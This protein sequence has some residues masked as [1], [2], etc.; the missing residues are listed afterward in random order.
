MVNNLLI[1]LNRC[2]EMITL[3]YVWLFLC[4]LC[5]YFPMLLSGEGGMLD[6]FRCIHVPQ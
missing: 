3:L 5:V 6:S 1:L 2:K 4:E